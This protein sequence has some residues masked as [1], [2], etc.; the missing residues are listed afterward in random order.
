MTNEKEEDNVNDNDEEEDNDDYINV[1]GET[2]V[3]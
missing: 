2:F 1:H 3:W